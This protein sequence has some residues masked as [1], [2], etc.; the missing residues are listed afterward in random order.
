MVQGHLDSH[1]LQ[2]YRMCGFHGMCLIGSYAHGKSE[3]PHPATFPPESWADEEREQK[4]QEARRCMVMGAE[5]GSRRDA[6]RDQMLTL[7]SCM[8]LPF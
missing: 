7:V 5:D 1:L 8:S 6:G 4:K 2:T 3:N